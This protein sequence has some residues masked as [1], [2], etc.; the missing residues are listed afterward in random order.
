MV[1]LSQLRDGRPSRWRRATCRPRSGRDLL[2]QDIPREM[3]V[4]PL[5]VVA[6][7]VAR[8]VQSDILSR[9]GILGHADLP[10]NRVDL[11]WLDLS[12]RDIEGP[13]RGADQLRAEN[14]GLFVVC[15]YM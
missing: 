5:A 11:E 8:I 4:E 12:H 9:L 1:V 7:K 13:F 2:D 14:V 15:G 10:R 3:V 6:D